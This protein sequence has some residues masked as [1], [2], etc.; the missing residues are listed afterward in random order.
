MPGFRKGRAPRKIL[1][2]RFA[3][4]LGREVKEKIVESAMKQLV[5]DKLVEPLRPP[6]IDLEALELAPET[7]L[8]FEF[9]L[10][11]KPEFETPTYEGLEITVPVVEVTDEILDGA[12]DRLR[13][14]EATLQTAEDA[15]VQDEDV[16]VVDWK[17]L[18]GDSVEAHDEN[19][20]YLYGR[21]VLA[22][23]VAEGLD[24]QLAGKKVGTTASVKVRVGPDDPREELRDKELDLE[25]ELKE[26]KRYVLP[27]IDEEFLQRHDFD[28]LEEM[29]EDVRKQIERAQSRERDREIEER[30]ISQLVEGVEMSLP[31]EF[32]ETELEAWAARKRMT[33]Q[34]EDV[35]AE[36][37]AKRIEAERAD[38][39]T[40]VENDM[41]RFFLLERIADEE[42]VKVAEAEMLQAIQAI[43]RATGRPEEDV[44]AQFR[45]GNRLSELVTQV[46]HRKTGE[47]IRRAAKIAEGPAEAPAGE[48]KPKKKKA[49]AK[50]KAT[51]K[52]KAA[53][54]KKAAPKK[55]A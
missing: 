45:D 42:D 27:E 9:D 28:D 18:D 33:L 52:K 10:V 14:S 26:V 15:S 44:L 2:K 22:G 50:K 49:A 53:A 46:R 35:E 40:S 6:Q 3:E 37:I 1:E 4:T 36:E 30:L 51:P 5:E 19:G 55:K 23:F 47:I 29:R 31:E 48:A 11:T 34:M 8:E 39:K 21:G 25:V 16:L 24:E 38:A 12:I 13:Q 54:K 20:Y 7:A 32:V 41:R 17:A 43:A